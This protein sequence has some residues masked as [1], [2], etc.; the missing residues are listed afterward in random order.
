[1]WELYGITAHPVRSNV[2]IRDLLLT[3]SADECSA[4]VTAVP[5]L[6]A[7]TRNKMVGTSCYQQTPGLPYQLFHTTPHPTHPHRYRSY[8]RGIVNQQE[9]YRAISHPLTL[10]H[11][12]HY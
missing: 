9:V 1:M 6:T 12:V 4:V 3:C 7:S 5:V 10:Q 8:P 2:A 11:F